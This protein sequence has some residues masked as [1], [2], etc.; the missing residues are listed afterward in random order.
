[1]QTIL[2]LAR[3]KKHV[4][5]DWNG[6]LLDDV[7]LAV[8]AI[9]EVL[10]ANNLPRIDRDQYRDQFCFPITEYY[11]RLGFEVGGEHF[12]TVTQGFVT[13]YRKRLSMCRL[14]E[15]ATEVLQ[16]IRT[17]PAKQSI[18][19]AAHEKDLHELLKHFGIAEFFDHVYG[20]SDHYAASKVE[21]GKELMKVSG[22]PV[23]DT[24]LIG[25]T[26]H[27]WEVGQA[28]GIDVILLGD[29]HQ[30]EGRLA[31]LGAELITKRGSRRS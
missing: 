17:W 30:H 27:D 16:A 9:G 20:L 5:W 22:V 7:D 29:G 28:L 1:M 25:D 26:D 3:K 10:E 8:E 6:T 14:H 23:K 31:D 12:E 11:R 21:R 19:S 2:T 24:V 4:I 15:G 18:L 13:G